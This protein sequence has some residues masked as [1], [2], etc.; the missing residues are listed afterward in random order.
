MFSGYRVPT[1]GGS[2]R[3]ICQLSGGPYADDG[4]VSNLIMQE[5]NSALGNINT[6]K[7]FSENIEN[8]KHDL[9]SLL[10]TIKSE[11]Q[12]IAGYGAPAKATTVMYHFGLGRELIDFIDDDSPLKPGLYSPGEHIIIAPSSDIQKF[13]PNFLLVFAWN[14]ADA[15]IRNNKNFSDAGG[16]FIL[17]FPNFKLIK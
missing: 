7:K 14:F 2:L 4:S 5:R 9:N 1:H 17:P 11:G 15:I 13:K 12:S 16:K 6:F 8:L 3:G 10:A